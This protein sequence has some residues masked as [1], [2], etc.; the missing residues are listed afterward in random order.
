MTLSSILRK[1][2]T[3]AGAVRKEPEGRGAVHIQIA[4]LSARCVNMADTYTTTTVRQRQGFIGKLQN[5]CAALCFG[6]ILLLIAPV[7]LWWN[8]SNV[9]QQ[10][11]ALHEVEKAV[12]EAPDK[13]STS[14]NGKLIHYNGDIS[15]PSG[16]AADRDFGIAVPG[17]LR[18]ARISEAYQTVEHSSSRTR[19][20]SNG[21]E[22]VDTTYSY[23][24]EWRSAL[25]PSSSFH[26][27]AK[28]RVNRH[29]WLIPPLV[30]T[31]REARLGPYKL[32]QE[33]IRNLGKE[34]EVD[35]RDPKVS[36]LADAISSGSISRFAL[37]EPQ[38]GPVK[39]ARAL[40]PALQQG[41][42]GGSLANIDSLSY[43]GGKLYTGNALAPAVNDNRVFFTAS[44]PTSASVLG[45]QSRTGE[46]VAWEASNGRSILLYAEGD[47][48]P[49]QLIAQA[50]SEA[51]TLLWALRGAGLLLLILAY[52]LLLQPA[53][54]LMGSVPLIGGI[55]GSVASCGACLASVLAGLTTTLL[56]V[57]VAWLWARPA[58]SIAL[59]LLAFLINVLPRWAGYGGAVKR[60]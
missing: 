15:L 7:M 23:S 35:M 4:G 42:T 9:V 40:V 48:S 53:V 22:V 21:N 33:V 1:A 3:A 19:K 36:K 52:A 10:Y 43:H 5:S 49:R 51:D 16:G 32:S 46:I 27:P 39:V 45:K 12:V 58:L 59:L 8:E 29:A 25:V 38:D 17:A 11:E 13:L 18:L 20:D 60:D 56:V 26:N 31:A 14:L 54:A 30:S 37:G 41:S 47:R 44:A 50:K 55:L 24:N 2:V 57:A 6:L 34:A 28:Q